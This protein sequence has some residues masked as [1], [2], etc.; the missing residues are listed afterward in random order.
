MDELARRFDLGQ[1]AR[2]SLPDR[3]LVP[4]RLAEG[5]A[6]ADVIEGEADRLARLGLVAFKGA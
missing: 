5:G 2:Q 3:L 1:S 6:L 4:Q